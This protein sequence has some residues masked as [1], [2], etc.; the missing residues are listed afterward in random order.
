MNDTQ[1]PEADLIYFPG[2]YPE[3]Y[4]EQLASNTS[5][6]ESVKEYA[7]NGGNILAECGGMMYLGKSLIDLNG[8]THILVG[9]FNFTAT[10]EDKKLSLGYRTYKNKDLTLKGH[11]FHY[12]KLIEEDKEEHIGQFINARGKEV[13]TKLYKYKNVLASYM[14]Y[15]LGSPEKIKSLFDIASITKS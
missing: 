2:G 9:V 15:Y 8:K 13:P 1:L 3:L 6:L 5:M 7:D 12:S 11:E 10:L 4:I 14:H